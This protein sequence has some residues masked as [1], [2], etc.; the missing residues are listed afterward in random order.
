MLKIGLDF[1]G[2]CDTYGALI[3][4]LSR[5]LV[6]QGYEVH[7]IT[8]Q[9]QEE[10]VD[11]VRALGIEFTHFF[12]ITDYHERINSLGKSKTPIRY[13][14]KGRP[15][16]DETIWNQTKAEYCNKNEIT[17]HIDDSEKYGKYFTTP[18]I[19][20]GKKHENTDR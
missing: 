18:Y 20:I 4:P 1:H 19:Y 6:E 9:K 10:I 16:M 11:M 13:D 17:I 3:A 8:G 7:I 2:V 5:Y 14:E 15:W 12:S